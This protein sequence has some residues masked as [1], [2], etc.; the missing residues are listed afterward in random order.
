MPR[1]RTIFMKRK[2]ILADLRFYG[3][4]RYTEDTGQNV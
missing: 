3:D 1:E 2:S 4:K